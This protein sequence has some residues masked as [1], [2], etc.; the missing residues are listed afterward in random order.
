MQRCWG[1]LPGESAQGTC[2]SVGG[3]QAGVCVTCQTAQPRLCPL[4]ATAGAALQ[5]DALLR[6]HGLPAP[7]EPQGRPAQEGPS[8]RAVSAFRGSEFGV[9]LAPFL[10][11]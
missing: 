9:T 2:G 6:G 4:R 3:E 1:H 5:P 10:G 8:E 11:I 7:A